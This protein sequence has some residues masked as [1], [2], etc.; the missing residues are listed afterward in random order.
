MCGILGFFPDYPCSKE[1]ISSIAETALAKLEHR[2]PNNRACSFF[3]DQE[4]GISY[5]LGHVRLSIID[6][7]SHG[8]QPF[9]SSDGRYCLV[10]NG[11][12]Y[13]YIEL[14]AEL[15]SLGVQ[16]VT[17]S[18]TEVVLQALLTWKE[19]ALLKFKGMFAF[20]LYDS[21]TYD[22]FCARDCFGIKPFY[23][24][25]HDREFAF[26]S[27]LPSLL[28]MSSV[29]REVNPHVAYQYLRFGMYDTTDET[30]LKNVYSL[31]SAHLLR[32]NLKTRATPRIIRYWT[33]TATTTFRGSF[34]DASAKLL[35]LLQNSI[36]LH[37][38][39]DVPVGLALSG[40]IDSSAIACLTRELNPNLELHSFCFTPSDSRLSEKKWAE[41]AN[42][43][44]RTINHTVTV[45]QFNFCD[46]LD[47]FITT[48]G[49]PVL[50]TSCYAQYNVYKSAHN[51]GLRVM[52]DGQGADELFAGYLGFPGQ[53][54]S[55]LL[56]Q[57]SPLHAVRFIQQYAQAASSKSVSRYG[58]AQALKALVPEAMLPCLL[59]VAGKSLKPKWLN[60]TELQDEL[61]HFA[62][63]TQK[64]IY[65][66]KNRLKQQ[67]GYQLFEN[68]LPRLLR[69]GD[70][71]S[72]AH[73][74][75]SRVPFLLPE[76]AEFSLSLPEH[77][78]VGPHGE[79]KHILRHALRGLV[80]DEIL[81]RKD[82][83]AFVTPEADWLS[84]NV[85]YV[86]ELFSSAVGI[87]FIR[88]K[89]M[90]EI[91][92][93]MCKEKKYTGAPIWRWVNYIRWVQLIGA[94]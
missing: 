23:W 76:I 3:F 13:N 18:D 70:R 51:M 19:D 29:K 43:K 80:P 77:F 42:K 79:A 59:T 31:P 85:D 9:Y 78:L 22:L 46:N 1:H 2:G 47:T 5:L 39:S 21:K 56:R 93:K 75:E 33:P 7:S 81:Q 91:W 64:N 89:V 30:F 62:L 15:S 41:V 60:I 53:R 4:D 32:F 71:N 16:F 66:I 45:S 57:G 61:L 6:L 84:G 90:Q 14:R 87:P 58:Y 69:H 73:S 63:P 92:M 20:A 38:R 55:S 12:V 65:S 67:L 28:S 88:Q 52:L 11:E 8:N 50:S 94:Y 86:S 48:M 68:G 27:E 49:E 36:E 82:K 83:V 24:S 25:L 72:M 10:Y 26:A 35:E 40:G 37:L 17:Q 34:D 74:I 44:A 54:F